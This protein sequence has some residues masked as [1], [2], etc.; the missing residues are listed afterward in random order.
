M[1]ARGPHRRR[2]PRPLERHRTER[3][4]PP[5]RRIQHRTASPAQTSTNRRRPCTRHHKGGTADP[6]KRDVGSRP[7]RERSPTMTSKRRQAIELARW[8]AATRPWATDTA[9]YLAL[10]LYH[11]RDTGSRPFRVGV[12][13]DEGERVWAETPLY[14]SADVSTTAVQAATSQPQRSQP[15]PW[16]VTNHRIVARLGDDRLHGWR[17]EQFV[18]CRVGLTLGRETVALD[19]DCQNPLVW[20]GAGA[21][22]PRCRRG[23]SPPRS[24]GSDRASWTR[25]GSRASSALRDWPARAGNHLWYP[26]ERAHEDCHDGRLGRLRSG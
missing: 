3:D 5:R 22:P 25:P 24:S 2:L 4:R 21:A 14:F 16:L 19:L 26:R 1:A 20:A 15:R 12:V 8:E 23:L 10:A 13:L 7:D 17:W 9:R 6:S 11:D 18:G